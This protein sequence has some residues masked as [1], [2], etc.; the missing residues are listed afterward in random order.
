MPCFGH[1]NLWR[2]DVWYRVDQGY[3]NL[4]LHWFPLWGKPTRLWFEEIKGLHHGQ[5][6][7]GTIRGCPVDVSVI[8][9]GFSKDRYIVDKYLNYKSLGQ[10]GW[11]LDRLID[12]ETLTIEK[13]PEKI[14]PDW[15][16]ISDEQNPINKKKLIELYSGEIS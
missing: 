1:Y 9:L 11:E 8:H 7:Q 3:H 15:F 16:K 14:I 13:L 10:K 5:V 12:E 4:H 2:S 6:P